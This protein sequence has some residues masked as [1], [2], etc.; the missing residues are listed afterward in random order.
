[1][2]GLVSRKFVINQIHTQIMHV[3]VRCIKTDSYM[4]LLGENNKSVSLKHV[5]KNLHVLKENLIHWVKPPSSIKPLTPRSSSDR[6]VQGSA[7]ASVWQ[8]I[9]PCT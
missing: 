4:L 1:M 5:K 7:W 6:N 8:Y 3:A 2:N 9:T